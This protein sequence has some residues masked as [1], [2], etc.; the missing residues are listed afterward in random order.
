MGNNLDSHSIELHTQSGGANHPL[1]A[2]LLPVLFVIRVE[3]DFSD[4]RE[5]VFYKEV[6]YA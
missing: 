3:I 4:Y 1:F 6:K 2:Y 5:G